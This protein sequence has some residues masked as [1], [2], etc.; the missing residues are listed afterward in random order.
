MVSLCLR[1]GIHGAR[2]R[3]VTHYYVRSEGSHKQSL[4]NP[5]GFAQFSVKGLMESRT[6]GRARLGWWRPG[7]SVM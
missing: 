2:S 4:Q 7:R 6:T 5:V 1:L 3:K